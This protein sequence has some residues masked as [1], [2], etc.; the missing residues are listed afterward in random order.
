VRRLAR[1]LA[2]ALALAAGAPATAPA[3]A[4]DRPLAA[5]ERID[6][7]QAPVEELM[8]LPGVGRKRADAIAALRERRPL[9]RPEDLAQVKGISPAWVAKHRALLEAS[10]PGASR[11]ATKP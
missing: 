3:A 8:R 9:R 1:A 11:A 7:N 5:G 6:L 2:A 10:P 4:K